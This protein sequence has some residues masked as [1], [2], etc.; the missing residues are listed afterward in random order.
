MS[1][2]FGTHNDY[3]HPL[4]GNL[5][6]KSKTK[7]RG[8]LLTKKSKTPKNYRIDHLMNDKNDKKDQQSLR[9]LIDKYDSPQITMKGKKGNINN[10]SKNEIQKLDFKQSNSKIKSEKQNDEANRTKKD[11]DEKI[12]IDPSSFTEVYAT[13]CKLETE[14]GAA[15]QVNKHLKEKEKYLSNKITDLNLQANV[16]IQILEE[17]KNSLLTENDQLKETLYNMPSVARLESELFSLTNFPIKDPEPLIQIG[18]LKPG[19]TL[20][21]LP[22]RLQDIF[23]EI[24]Q[25]EVDLPFYPNYFDDGFDEEEDENEL[26]RKISM[27]EKSSESSFKIANKKLNDLQSEI[28]N[29]RRDLSN[30]NMHNSISQESL[31]NTSFNFDEIARVLSTA[32]LETSKLKQIKK[33]VY[34]YNDSFFFEVEA[35]CGRPYAK[36]VNADGESDDQE[37]S[38]PLLYYFKSIKN[39]M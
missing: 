37:K 29:L 6:P 39:S 1:V 3:Q 26:R 20:A 30:I 11:D 14:L 4:F 22:K 16:T 5:T 2:N 25:S 35:K 36:N 27:L 12:N 33:N 19:E 10:N 24:K 17:R 21:V 31:L 28:E 23:N 9:K 13:K 8:D 15:I 38:Y 7:I 32:R 18:I 34:S